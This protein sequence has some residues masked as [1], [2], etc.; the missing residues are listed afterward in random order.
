M[1]V[2]MDTQNRL[3][4]KKEKTGN[5]YQFFDFFLFS[6]KIGFF[7]SFGALIFSYPLALFMRKN[8]IWKKTLPPCHKKHMMAYRS[9]D[10]MILLKVF[11]SRPI[12][13]K[14]TVHQ[15]L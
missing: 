9:P 3:R 15:Y 10:L 11:T 12:A 7:S 14:Q 4:P 8:F 5:R 1:D 2:V 6:M 13:W